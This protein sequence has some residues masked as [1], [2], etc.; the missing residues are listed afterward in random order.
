M[1]GP[2]PLLQNLVACLQVFEQLFRID[3]RMEK[4]SYYYYID[5]ER[6]YIVERIE[7]GMT[8]CIE[9]I[10]SGSF[11]FLV[12]PPLF[13]L[14]LLLLFLALS[15]SISLSTLSLSLWLLF[16]FRLAVM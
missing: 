7:G 2:W 13:I 1:V 8:A 16:F 4:D 15:V 12:P 3:K 5:D 14:I 6:G 9:V 10:W 11:F